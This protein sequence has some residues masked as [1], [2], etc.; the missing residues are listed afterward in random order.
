MGTFALQQILIGGRHKIFR[1]PQLNR[2]PKQ[3]EMLNASNRYYWDLRIAF[4]QGGEQRH[5][6][7][8]KPVY[9]EEHSCEGLHMI[10][11]GKHIH[12]L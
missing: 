12:S 8:H 4:A 1:C 3:F 2:S 9:I 7:G 5:L 6:V 10:H 11:V